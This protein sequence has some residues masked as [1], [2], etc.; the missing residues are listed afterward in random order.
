MVVWSASRGEIAH[1]LVGHAGAVYALA[2]TPSGRFLLS[3][4]HDASVRVWDTWARAAM[5]AFTGHVGPVFAVRPAPS[6]QV[7]TFPR[8]PGLGGAARPFLTRRRLSDSFHSL[9][10]RVTRPPLATPDEYT[11]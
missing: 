11:P 5:H 1:R 9:V 7:S 4:S 10:C 3:G 6:C 2:Y 8:W